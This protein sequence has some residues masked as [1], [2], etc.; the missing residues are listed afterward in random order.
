[1]AFHTATGEALATSKVRKG[2]WYLGEMPGIPR[3]LV[4]E[5][6]LEFLKSS[7]AALTLEL[8]EKIAKDTGTIK[9]GKKTFGFAPAKVR[10]SPSFCAAVSLL[11]RSRR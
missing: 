8:A 1:V 11:A 6:D 9:S 4:Y 5:P 2:E 10:S 3:V 7:Q